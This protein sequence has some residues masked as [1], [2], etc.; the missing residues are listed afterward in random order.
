MRERE[1]GPCLA[2]PLPVILPLPNAPIQETHDC[3]G[4]VA[5]SSHPASKTPPPPVQAT[6]LC[7]LQQA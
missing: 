3:K 1:A 2:L 7:R 4:Y 6:V 5:F